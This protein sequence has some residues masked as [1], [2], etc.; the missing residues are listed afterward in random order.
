[1]ND[2]KSPLYIYQ[3]V[4]VILKKILDNSVIIEDPE[5][6]E[7]TVMKDLFNKHYTNVNEII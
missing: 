3:G 7:M 6:G 4:I 1:M 5:L 2:Y